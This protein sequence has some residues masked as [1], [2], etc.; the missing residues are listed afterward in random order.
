MKLGTIVNW[1]GGSLS[2]TIGAG[3]KDLH[4]LTKSSR[5]LADMI[6]DLQRSSF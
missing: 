5:V 2:Y 1:R 4:Q 3:E 6:D